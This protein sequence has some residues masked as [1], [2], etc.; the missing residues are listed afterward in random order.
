[1]KDTLGIITCVFD[2]PKIGVMCD[3][4]PECLKFL[5]DN[6]P[7]PKCLVPE[8]SKLNEC[9]GKA[10]GDG[11][12]VCEDK[13]NTVTFHCN[14]NA[15]EKF[16]GRKVHCEIPCINRPNAT[17]KYTKLVTSTCDMN[18]GKLILLLL[19]VV[20]EERRGTG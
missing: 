9:K 1:M 5:V 17:K 15:T 20:V 10:R 8:L 13:G 6:D 16:Q 2:F 12:V 4:P 14:F 7:N 18:I 3:P 11:I 19:V